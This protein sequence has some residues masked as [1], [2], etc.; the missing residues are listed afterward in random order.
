[1]LRNY[2]SIAIRNF[3]SNPLYSTINILSLSIGIAACLVIYLFISDERSFDSFHSKKE[4]VYRLNETQNFTGTNFQ[5][6]A[7][8]GG[9]MGPLIVQEFPEIE[10]YTRYW[11]GAKRM[12]QTGDKQIVV[13]MVATV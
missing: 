8:T 2:V 7:L 9:P 3:R 4:W 6:V 5:K 13:D 10:N 1:M 12:L 11:G